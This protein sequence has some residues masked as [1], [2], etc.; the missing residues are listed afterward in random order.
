MKRLTIL[1]VLCCPL[2][3][4]AQDL[5]RHIDVHFFP[6]VLTSEDTLRVGPAGRTLDISEPTMLIW[7]DLFPDMFFAHKTAYI[8]IS[9]HRIRIDIDSYPDPIGNDRGL[10]YRGIGVVRRLDATVPIPSDPARVNHR[11]AITQVDPGLGVVLDLI[12]PE[13]VGRG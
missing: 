3:L 12:S 11:G 1:I 8:L 13:D 10:A 7:V 9:K 5:S 6:H 2:S 4:S